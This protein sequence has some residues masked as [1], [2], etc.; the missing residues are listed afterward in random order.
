MPV[1]VAVAILR[2]RL[3]EIDRII[4]R[5]LVYGLLTASLA[6]TYWGGAVIMQQL[7]RPFTEGSE[8]AIVLSTLA[9]VALFQPARR[10]I[11]EVVDRRF[12]RQK[13]DAAK[14]L[15]AFSTHVRDEVDLPTLK[16][17]LVT[18]VYDTMQPSHVSLWIRP[19]YA[20]P[21]SPDRPDQA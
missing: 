2:Y 6:L 17:E 11:Q 10:R 7:L 5:A 8:L 19:T 9:V 20:A 16:H 1:A 12:Y 21:S 15:A 13:Y 14:T 4:N 18:V 3:Y